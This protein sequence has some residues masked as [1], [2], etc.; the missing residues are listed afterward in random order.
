PKVRQVGLLA[1]DPERPL[2]PGTC[3]EHP[4]ILRCVTRGA[5]RSLVPHGLAPAL[6][7]RDQV[8]GVLPRR[9]STIQG[10]VP[11]L[12]G[13]NTEEPPEAQQVFLGVW[14]GERTGFTRPPPVV[15]GAI[16]LRV[17]FPPLAR[18]LAILLGILGAVLRAESARAGLAMVCRT[19][20]SGASAGPL[21]RRPS[22]PAPGT[23]LPRRD[24]DLIG[25]SGCVLLPA[26]AL[27][28]ALVRPIT[29]PAVVLQPVL[30]TLRS[31]E[32]RVGKEGRSRLATAQ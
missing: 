15:L 21:R 20:N 23:P 27:V 25:P 10:A 12:V 32:R 6:G 30:H 24:R 3:R 8:V 16:L 9:I 13:V 11:A 28:L 14:D 19:V 31:E 22:N 18:V 1:G 2:I 17:G 26:L 29:L 4:V 5:R 7:Q